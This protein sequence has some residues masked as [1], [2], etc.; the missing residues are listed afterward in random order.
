MNVLTVEGVEVTGLAAYLPSDEVRNDEKTAK[1]TGIVSRR[2][3][4]EGTDVLDLCVRAAEKVLADT[5]AQPAD[6]G[7]ILCV[8]F[9]ARDRMPAVAIQAQA[10]LGFPKDLI[11]FDVSLACSG[12]CYGLYLAGLLARQTGRKVLLLDGDVQSARVGKDEGV[13]PLL[14]DAGTAT[15]VGAGTGVWRFAFSADGGKGAAL[16]LSEGGTIEMDGFGVFKF[17][18]TDVV[19]A[20]REFVRLCM[21]AASGRDLA[22]VPHQPNVYMIRQLAKSVEMDETQTKISCDEFGNLASASIPVTLVHRQVRGK[23]LLAGFGGGLSI[24]LGFVDLPASCTL[25]LV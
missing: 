4:S 3:A 23:V 24:S 5:G 1:A 7:A 17:V 21:P 8:S 2:V 19:L 10:R 11:A 13:R 12:W 20:V 14:G 25:G 16:K 9:T 18:A 22:F 15:V 6:F